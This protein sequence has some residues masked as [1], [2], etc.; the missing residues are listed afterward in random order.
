LIVV[1][2]ALGL[3]V[4]Q[5]AQ[6]QS[7]LHAEPKTVLTDVVSDKGNGHRVAD[8]EEQHFRCTSFY[9]PY[10]LDLAPQR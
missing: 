7:F 1:I 6:Y 9:R 5:T 8:P 2:S 4:L 10:Q 3:T